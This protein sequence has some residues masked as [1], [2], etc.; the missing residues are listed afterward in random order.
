MIPR[1]P[2]VLL[3][4]LAACAR[5]APPPPAVGAGAG[6][7]VHDTVRSAALRGNPLGD[8]PDRAVEVYLPPS[9]HARPARR[10]PVVYL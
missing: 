5:P 7:V 8:S 1:L 4:A 3:L 9:Y 10:Y 2:S 6:V